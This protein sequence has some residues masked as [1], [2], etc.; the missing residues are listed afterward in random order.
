MPHAVE[1]IPAKM[2]GHNGLGDALSCQ[3]GP[4]PSL[5]CLCGVRR[6]A[7]PHRQP[8]ATPHRTIPPPESKRHPQ[9]VPEHEARYPWKNLTAWVIVMPTVHRE[10]GFQFRVFPNDHG[11]AHVH[12]IKAG[13]SAKISVGGNP[14]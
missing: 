10:S 14:W 1:Q 4:S 3:Y 8:P 5:T 12:A 2:N 6:A 11:P 7:V 9:G 13:G